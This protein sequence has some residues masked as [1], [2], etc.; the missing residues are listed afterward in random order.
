MERLLHFI[1]RLRR[2]PEPIR[3]QIL[4]LSAAVITVIIAVFWAISLRWQLGSSLPSAGDAVFREEA[5]SSVRE[6]FAKSGAVLG[7]RVRDALHDVLLGD[8]PKAPESNSSNEHDTS[9]TGTPNR[10]PSR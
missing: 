2:Y 3:R 4:L 9:K 8:E 5:R 6:G 1:E 10:L 7:D